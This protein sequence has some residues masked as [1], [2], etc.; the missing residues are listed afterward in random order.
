MKNKSEQLIFTDIDKQD[1]KDNV[2]IF[3]IQKSFRGGRTT[4]YALLP[5]DK[6]IRK[7]AWDYQ[8]EE[9]GEGTSGGH[10][11][12]YSINAKEVEEIPEKAPRL[13]FNEDYLE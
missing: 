9:W 1:L 5:K 4:Y 7:S 2:K 12:G 13:Y 10:E 3:Q 11:D 8:F 6:N